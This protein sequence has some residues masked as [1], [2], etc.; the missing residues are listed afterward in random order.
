MIATVYNAFFLS[1]S[2]EVIAGRATT[3]DKEQ[4]AKATVGW[5]NIYIAFSKKKTRDLKE[6]T[7]K[8]TKKK[9]QLKNKFL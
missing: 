3:V 7:N 9:Q 8:Q 6:E 5:T 4:Q 1:L 2:S